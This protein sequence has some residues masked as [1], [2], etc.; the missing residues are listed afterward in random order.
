[1]Y[2]CQ[3]TVSHGVILQDHFLNHLINN[4][5]MINLSLQAYVPDE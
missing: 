2:M 1:M 5:L 3:D 4:D